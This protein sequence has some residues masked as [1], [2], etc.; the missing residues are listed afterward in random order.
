MKQLCGHSAA[1]VVPFRHINHEKQDGAIFESVV[2][3]MFG[4]QLDEQMF[5][6]IKLV[7]PIIQELLTDPLTGIGNRRAFDSHC[8][9]LRCDIAQGWQG[10]FAIVDIDHFKSINDTYGHYVGDRLLS[11]IA[12]QCSTVVGDEGFAARL[13]GDEFAVTRD[14]G[15][16]GEARRL[17][18]HLVASCRSAED[19]AC[20]SSIHASVSI[21]CVFI[22]AGSQL[23]SSEELFI[24]ADNG[25]YQS[26]RTGR[27][28][29][30]VVEFLSR[31]PMTSA[32]L[33][34]D[35]MTCS[36]P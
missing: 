15:S 17:M 1:P 6:N 8:D 28:R 34:A 13:G 35:E 21:G 19:G 7:E 16:L 2:G 4:T 25:L 30:S 23:N 11:R 20:F 31:M 3:E 14:C 22:A 36:S 5:V 24:A 33:S 27:C 10:V 9:L 29:A 26:K 18:A 12:S 32:S